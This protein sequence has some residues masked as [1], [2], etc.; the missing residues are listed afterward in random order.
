MIYAGL[1]QFQATDPGN[2]LKDLVTGR[3]LQAELP[4]QEA[5]QAPRARGGEHTC[6]SEGI[7]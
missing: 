5:A 7:E 2:D 3:V 4:G 6:N 1:T